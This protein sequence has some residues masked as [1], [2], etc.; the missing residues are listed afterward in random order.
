MRS[1]WSTIVLLSALAFAGT[2][3]RSILGIEQTQ[4]DPKACTLLTQRIFFA[5]KLVSDTTI[6]VGVLTQAHFE[7][8]ARGIGAS[9][10][11]SRGHGLA[12]IVDCDDEAAEFA[13]ADFDPMGVGET[14]FVVAGDGLVL[15]TDTNV[16]GVLGALNLETPAELLVTAYPDEIESESSAGDI[17]TRAGELS[18]IRLH[19]NSEVVLPSPP[20]V[21]EWSCVGTIP[22]PMVSDPTITLTV[23]VQESTA[24]VPGGV[25]VSG[26]R[27]AVCL[28]EAA[29]CDADAPVA[30]GLSA[31]TDASGRVQLVVDTGD[32]GFDGHLVVAGPDPSCKP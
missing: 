6:D 22:D 14:S 26:V 28:D 17:V 24:F 8:L 32:E 13:A 19:P 23:V 30:D 31:V 29:G 25:P 1:R 27:V 3:C 2:G 12:E 4:L 9:L 15:G 7:E 20:S 11:P 10:D 18:R 21:D 16:E 5:D